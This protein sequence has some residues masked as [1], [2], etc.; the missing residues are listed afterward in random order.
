MKTSFFLYLMFSALQEMVPVAYMVICF[1]FSISY[2][3]KVCLHYSD[4]GVLG[5]TLGNVHFEEIGI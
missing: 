1:S 3:F 2:K 5:F 4:I